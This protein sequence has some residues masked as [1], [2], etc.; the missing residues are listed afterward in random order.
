M[1]TGFAGRVA[2][3]TGANRGIG[4]E[5]C[6]QLAD[7]GVVV[8]LGARDAAKGEAAAAELTAGG[9]DV[10]F[11][12]ID[13]ASDPSVAAAAR[14]MDAEAGRLDILVNNAGINF[15]VQVRTSEADLNTIKETLET[16]LFGAWR[17]TMAFLPLLRRS[18]HPRIVNVSSEVGGFGDT[19]GSPFGLTKMGGVLPAYAISKTALNALTVKLALDLKESGV[20]VNAVCPGFTAT[21]PGTAEMGARPVREGAEGIV[22]AALLSDDG[23]TGGFFRDGQPLPW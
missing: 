1:S 9:G 14:W 10:R 16:N 22:R 13:V 19:P 7:Q 6:R 17:T 23:P 21:A 11:C 3:V 4:Y 2:L 8:Y 12:A 5:V 18:E 20:L 15:D